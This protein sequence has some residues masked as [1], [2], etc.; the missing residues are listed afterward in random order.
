MIAQGY[1]LTLEGGEGVGKT[2]SLTFVVDYLQSH[3]IEPVVTREPGGTALGEAVRGLLLSDQYT[4][5][6]VT[7][8]ML[9]FAAR[10]EHIQQVIQPALQ[11]GRVVVSDRY[12]DASYAYQGGGRGLSMDKIQ[13]LQ[14]WLLSFYSNQV[15]PDLVLL[16]DAPLSVTDQRVQQRGQVKDRFEQEQRAFFERVRE[17]YRARADDSTPGNTRYQ[18]IDASVD[19]AGVQSQL[20][21]TLDQ[22]LTRLQVHSKAGD[23]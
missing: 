21:H 17:A 16:L 15:L 23:T 5:D 4:P 2:T 13:A 11:A 12:L 20:R 3:G 8:L 22:L 1:L 6:A 9:M 18:I 7:E 14:D 19:L 10:N